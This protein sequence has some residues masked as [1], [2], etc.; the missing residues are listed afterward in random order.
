MHQHQHSTNPDNHRHNPNP[1]FSPTASSII[2][3]TPPTSPISIFEPPPPPQST[4]VP[5]IYSPSPSSSSP[6]D[7]LSPLI[8]PTA[9]RGQLT[10]P[11]TSEIETHNVTN[12]LTRH[13][14]SSSSSFAFHHDHELHINGGATTQGLGSDGIIGNGYTAISALPPPPLNVV[15]MDIDLEMNVEGGDFG[16]VQNVQIARS[17]SMSSM[18]KRRIAEIWIRYDQKEEFFD[19]DMP[20]EL[21]GLLEQW[22]NQDRRIK[23]VWECKRLNHQ[24]VSSLF[25]GLFFGVRVNWCINVDHI[26]LVSLVMEDGG[27]RSRR[28][29]D[30][31]RLDDDDGFDLSIVEFECLP[32]YEPG[33]TTANENGVDEGGWLTCASG[34]SGRGLTSLG[35]GSDVRLVGGFWGDKDYDTD[36]GGGVGMRMIPVSTG[37][38][39]PPSYM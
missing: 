28:L 6:S 27:V 12:T 15:E 32:A 7:A 18:V 8:L 23:L 4:P 5:N 11:T 26:D 19:T 31:D 14:A 24:T 10:L 13:T 1:P 30:A 33:S 2:F 22:N 25:I 34:G 36:D 21:E 9:I 37:S 3:P 38:T 29:L 20:L 17:T 16:G 35:A 39:R